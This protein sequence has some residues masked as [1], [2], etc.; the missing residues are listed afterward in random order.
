MNE[1][2]LRISIL[3]P[4]KTYTLATLASN[5]WNWWA[6]A[7]VNFAGRVTTEDGKDAF[8]DAWILHTDLLRWGVSEEL[9][10]ARGPVFTIS[11]RE[12]F[13]GKGGAEVS[14]RTRDSATR[15]CM[16]TGTDASKRPNERCLKARAARM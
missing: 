12:S 8:A 16:C 6:S 15:V 10:N 7:V 3:E 9:A 4:N 5:E 1:Y 14:V 13:W 11:E 2:C